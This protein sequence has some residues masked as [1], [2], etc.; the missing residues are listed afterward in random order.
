MISKLVTVESKKAGED[1]AYRW[2]S[3]GADG[4][5]IEEC[6]KEKIGTKIIL[7]LK[8]NTED[9]NFDSYLDIYFIN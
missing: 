4:Y 1:K 5:T 9:E 8:D 7:D 3:S 2:I 6:D